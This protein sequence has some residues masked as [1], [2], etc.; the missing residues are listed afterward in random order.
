MVE[1]GVRGGGREWWRGGCVVGREWWR[2]ALVAVR[3]WWR[4]AL[5]AV[6][7]P[8]C[9][10]LVCW[11]RWRCV[12]VLG[13]PFVIHWGARGGERRE[14]RGA[15][16]GERVEE[17]G[18][19]GGVVPWSPFACACWGIITVH[20]CWVLI[21]IRAC[22]CWALIHSSS[23]M[24]VLHWLVI[25]GHVAGCLWLQVSLCCRC[26]RLRIVSCHIVVFMCRGWC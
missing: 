21:T 16:N 4:W 8:W 12:V 17:G 13:H 23:V 11:R 9:W 2:W 20:M 14:E 6:H 26:P 10:A 3:A 18:G 22:W 25:R 24:F 1:G 19:R 5:E 15:R 7:V